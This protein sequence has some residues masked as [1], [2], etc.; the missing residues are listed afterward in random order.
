[1]TGF[2]DL[3]YY[4]IFAPAGT[5]KAVID[6]TSE[7]VAKVLAQ[8]DV[9]ERLTAMGLTVGHMTPQQLGNREKAYTATWARIIKASGFQAQ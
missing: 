4:G 5:P 9:K 6:R 8:A 7:A 3:P 1:L 2:E